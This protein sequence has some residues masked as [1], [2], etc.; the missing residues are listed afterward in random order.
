M[1]IGFITSSENNNLYLK[2]ES[3]DKVLLAEIFV[4]NIIFGGNEMMCRSFANEMRK[5]FEMS[6][7]G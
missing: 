5:K 3:K 4:D 6:F 2:S 7:I 1:R